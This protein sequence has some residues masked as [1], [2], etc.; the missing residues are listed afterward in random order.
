MREQCNG[1]RTTAFVL[2]EKA[3]TGSRSR[4]AEMRRVRRRMGLREHVILG[5][6]DEQNKEWSTDMSSGR[7]GRNSGK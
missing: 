2:V 7:G 3:F 5:V 6:C 4:V 1:F